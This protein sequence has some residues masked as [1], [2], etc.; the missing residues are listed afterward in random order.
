MTAKI[1]EANGEKI[2]V[3]DEGSGPAVLFIHSLGT[4][5][6][7]LYAAQIAALK[8]RYRCIAPDCRGHGATSYNGGF[9]VPDVAAD[10][11]AVLDALGVAQAHVVGLSMG[12]PIA[13]NFNARWPEMVR[14]LVIADSFARLRDQQAVQDRVAATRET[15]A[16][17]SMREFGSQYAADRL[18]PTTPI[19]KLD[20]LADEVAK[21]PPNAYVDTVQAIFTYDAS[22]DLAKVRVPALVLVGDQDDATP[23]AENAFIRDGIKGATLEEIPQAGH[24]STI[25][26]PGEFTRRLSA[27][28]DRQPK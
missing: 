13:L 10:H 9:T 23:M 27:F 28:L 12:G 22:G 6:A 21:C 2:S 17:I 24:L 8:A 16:Y 14:S 5:G 7:W 25:D 20:E 1:I 19:E 18:L 26:N 3:V 4:N 15:V 11:K